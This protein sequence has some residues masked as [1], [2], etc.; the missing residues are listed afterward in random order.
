MKRKSERVTGLSSARVEGAAASAGTRARDLIE[1]VDWSDTPLGDR[2]AW[3]HSLKTLLSTLQASGH[4]MML[5]WGPELTLFYNDAYA[6]MLGNRHPWAFGRPFREA[7]ADIWSEIE[8]LVGRAL[9]GES[10]WMEDYHLVMHRNGYPEDTWWQFS[11]S[12]VSDERGD[13]VG[14]L[15]VTSEMTGKMIAERRLREMNEDLEA[16]VVERTRDRNGLWQLSRDIM[17]RSTFDGVITT[18]N[19][20]W[21]EVLGWSE[22]ELVGSSLFDLV[23]PDDLERTLEGAR[24]LSEGMS[25]DRFDNRYR[26]QDGS[27]RWISW[28]TRS[29]EGLINAVGRDFTAEKEKEEA[30]R[31]AEDALRQAQKMEA[32]GQLTGGLA[33]DFNNLLTGIMGNLELLQLRIARGRLDDVDRFVLAAQG[34]GRRAAA[35]TQ[36][37]LAFSRRQT[38][39]PK[40]T[41]V[42]RLVSGM[43]D[44]LRRTVGAMVDIEVVGA[45][46]LWTTMID[47]GQLEN[48]ILNLCINARDAMPTGGRLTIETANKWLDD[49]SAK[50]R[51]LD[52]GQYLS[53]CVTDTGT[54]MSV[55][56]VARAFDPFYTTKPLGEGTGLGLSMVYG[57]V[58]QSGG[59]ARIYTEEGVGTTVCLYLPRHHGEAE[60]E[61]TAQAIELAREG[62]GET[63][64]VVDDEATV[65]HLI[66][67]VLDEQGYTVINA[68][69]GAAGLKVVQSGAVIDLL[70]TD[71]A[72]PNGM[73]GRQVADAARAIRPGLKVLFITGFAE[74]AAVGNGHLEPGMALLAK[75]FTLDDL[76]RK[77]RDMLL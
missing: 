67:E 54:G 3:P 51:G 35:L 10:I 4:G 74:N 66:D 77:V 19:P 58:R 37:L 72:L 41:D 32:V 43:E 61:V 57:F 28:T 44:M 59:Q 62:M 53:V 39:D 45:A 27:Y 70:V 16:R 55:E 75:P 60:D 20:A 36:R 7:W 42:N 9:G 23:H 11:Y 46:G 76:T 68:A 8:P 26:H 33:H 48:A 12:P 31:S 18:V 24:Q 63:I 2:G 38:L 14:M 47:A 17:L 15:N 65:R 29:G 56:T 52:P 22:V 64:L 5:A 1:G 34:A 6:P 25:H 13:I 49:R 40:P 30:L 71:V 69:D 21:Q 50:E 73:N